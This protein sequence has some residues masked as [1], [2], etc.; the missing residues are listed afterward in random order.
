MRCLLSSTTTR[1]SRGEEK[2]MMSEE[3]GTIINSP[4]IKI[5]ANKFP[6][7]HAINIL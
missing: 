7:P 3:Y 4:S 5:Q 1:K 6:K 2:K